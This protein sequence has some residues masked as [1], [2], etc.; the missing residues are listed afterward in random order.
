[1]K[2]ILSAAFVAAYVFAFFAVGYVSAEPVPVRGGTFNVGHGHYGGGP[3]GTDIDL[4]GNALIWDADGDLICSAVTDDQLLCTVADSGTNN[5]L[6]SY[7]FQR[8]SSGT[9]AS[10]FGVGPE[11]RLE[12][13]SGTVEHAG[14]LLV[15]WTDPIG[16]AATSQVCLAN[17]ASSVA[18]NPLCVQGNGDVQLVNNDTIGNTTN[19]Q[20]TF[21]AD[22]VEDLSMSLA[23]PDTVVWSSSTGVG[24]FDVGAMSIMATAG[25][26][27]DSNI[28]N[29]GDIDVD[30]ISAD[31][32]NIL[33]DA[34]AGTL[35]VS[36]TTSHLNNLSLETTKKLCLNTGC[37]TYSNESASSTMSIY[38]GNNLVEQKTAS[39]MADYKERLL[40][41]GARVYDDQ[42]LGFGADTDAT[43]G[44]TTATD[45]LL[46]NM[47]DVTW[48]IS[49]TPRHLGGVR[50][51]LQTASPCATAA[52]PEGSIFYNDTSDYMC[53]CVAGSAA[54]QLHAPATNC[55]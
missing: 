44:Y 51:A 6:W 1:M 48:V 19:N 7:R 10:E 4:N 29:V 11:V 8:T 37:T 54:K 36:G 14:G 33:I 39:Y 49:G 5:A 53:L 45:T 28:T 35:T 55:F 15:K 13:S 40:S 43:I 38:V 46:F 23:G 3:V 50:P 26:F 25:D 34:N 31:G 32:T 30:S 12:T 41:A 16:G 47:S 17:V 27:G 9:T 21:T 18:Q 2:K 24:S 20:F 52:F 22:S 42:T